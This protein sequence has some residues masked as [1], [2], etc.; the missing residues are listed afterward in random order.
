M[1]I[2]VRLN[3]FISET[4]FC[5][6]RE[7]DEY[8]ETGRVTVNGKEPEIGMKINPEKDRIRIDGEII[9]EDK[10]FPVSEKEQQAMGWRAV[11]KAK[12]ETELAQAAM[13][14]KSK[15]LRSG[16][17][18]SAINPNKI[19]EAEGIRPQRAPHSKQHKISTR[20]AGMTFEEAISNPQIIASAKA[21]KKETPINKK[22]REL[23]Q[24]NK[25]HGPSAHCKSFN[26]GKKR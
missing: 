3:K 11:R 10:L 19:Q 1:D 6:R 14:P 24:G 18:Q 16:R 12:K 9:R 4:G 7:A 25:N 22:S 26:R 8:I 21:H 23:R 13:N 5:S 17:K 2:L 20:N 15:T